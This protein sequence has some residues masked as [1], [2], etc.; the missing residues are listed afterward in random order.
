[1]IEKDFEDGKTL[2]CYTQ[3]NQ[4]ILNISMQNQNIAKEI[5]NGIIDALKN[6]RKTFQ[7]RSE[8][9]ARKGQAV[10]SF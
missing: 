1:M 3:L 2:A 10:L 6:F 7:T 5:A 8:D 9:I 4:M